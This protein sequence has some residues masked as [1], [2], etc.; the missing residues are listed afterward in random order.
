MTTYKISKG[1]W[2]TYQLYNSL[3]EAELWTLNNLGDGYL[4]ELSPDIQIEPLTPEEKLE[5]DIQFG[6]YLINRFLKENREVQPP[7]TIQQSLTLSQKFSDI[8]KLARLGDMKSVLYLMLFV[9]TDEVF[10]IER[11]QEY[12]N[13]LNGYL[14]IE[15]Q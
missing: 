14:G 3:Q 11:K 9:T 12:L 4:V 7:V 13:L 15:N 10:T 6:N 8:E 2:S 5:Q 1:A